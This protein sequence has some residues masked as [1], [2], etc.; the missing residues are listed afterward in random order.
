G[1]GKVDLD[2]DRRA[3][4]VRA[5]RGRGGDA[6][7]GRRGRVDDEVLV[8][9]Q[10][11]G[12]ARRGERERGGVER[13]VADRAAV[14]RQRAGTDVAEVG[15]GIA[16]RDG[17]GEGQRRAAAAAGVVDDLVRGAGLERQLRRAG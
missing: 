3:G 13:A 17:V 4:L 2:R 14:E 15:G 16:R 7:D 1:L 10:A 9:A 6:A 5:V 11:A 8:R 12:G